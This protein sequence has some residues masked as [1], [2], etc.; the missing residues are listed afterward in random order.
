MNTVQASLIHCEPVSLAARLAAAFGW[1]TRK[2]V[3][4]ARD[5]PDHLKRDLG[6]LDGNDPCGRRL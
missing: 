6:F 5:L 2:R 3:L 1:G 4:D